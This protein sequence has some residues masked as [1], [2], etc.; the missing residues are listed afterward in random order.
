MSRILY[1]TSTISSATGNCINNNGQTTSFQVQSPYFYK[2][3]EYLDDTNL[4]NYYYNESIR[5]VSPSNTTWHTGASGALFSFKSNLVPLGTTNNTPDCKINFSNNDTSSGYNL[6]AIDEGNNV[7]KVNFNKSSSIVGT[8]WYRLYNGGTLTALGNQ[9][10]TNVSSATTTLT[11]YNKITTGTYN[12]YLYWSGSS[13]N[14]S[15]PAVSN[16]NISGT[17]SS[18]TAPQLFVR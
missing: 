5:A 6:K 15:A 12:L 18:N 3:N 2:P 7:I 9:G 11:L 4:I 14:S 8:I 17:C 16:A 10:L 13:A 1:S